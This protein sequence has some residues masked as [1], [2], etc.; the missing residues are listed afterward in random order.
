MLRGLAAGATLLWILTCLRWFDAG[1][2]WRPAWLETIPPAFLSIPGAALGVLW[3]RR[4]WRGF[5][6]PL[7]SGS[8]GGLLLVVVLAV[9]FR[10][11]L[12]WQGAAGYTTADGALSGIVAL[13]IRDGRA[14]DVF[15]PQVPYSGSLKSHVAAALSTGIESARAFTLV[16]TAFY[17]L[18]VAALYRLALL[19]EADAA[20]AVVAGLY[21]AFSPAWVTHYSLSNDGNYV[22]VLALGGW[23][24]VLAARW[25]RAPEAR[26]LVSLGLGLLLGLAFWCHILSVIHAAAIGLTL[27]LSDRWAALRALPASASGFGLGYFPGLLW[28]AGNGWESFRSLLPG[29]QPAVASP[30]GPGVLGRALATLSDHAPVLLGYDA[31]YSGA[32]DALL[33]C[34]ALVAVVVVVLSLF[35]AAAEARSRRPDALW[36]LLMM[37]AVNVALAVVVLRYVPENPRYLLFLMAPLPILMARLLGRGPWRWLMALLIAVGAVASLVQAR[38]EI[39]EDLEWRRF[40]ADLEAADVRFCYSDFYVATRI[41]FLSEE[42]VVCSSKLGPTRTEY[43]FEYRS[44]VDS[45]PEA[46]YVAASAAQADKLERRLQRLEVVYER[47]DLMK[48]LLRRLSRKVDPQ[49]LFPDQSFGLR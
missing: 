34:A 27:L 5:W 30:Q 3:L 14:H 18:F 32:A 26:A 29:S 49:E 36:L 44:L 37:T 23:A 19:V 7:P 1:A 28:N 13:H 41:N 20:T 39:R 2:P 12:A 9:A 38:G 22:E 47:R 35:R 15:V 43:F 33:R 17:A 16:S 10:L 48:P 6:E 45:A 21:A 4:R 46:D 8:L 24:L 25:L 40:A 42:R 31:G 11:P